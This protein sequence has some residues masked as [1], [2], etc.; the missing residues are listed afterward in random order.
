VELSFGGIALTR[1]ICRRCNA[2]VRNTLR[3]RACGALHPTSELRAAVLSP[4][5][6]AFYS[7]LALLVALWLW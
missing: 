3:C 6:A 4:S 7:I 2:D 1:L 5:A